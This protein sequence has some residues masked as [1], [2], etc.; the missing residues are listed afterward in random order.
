MRNE[1]WQYVTMSRTMRTSGP[2][3]ET[4]YERNCCLFQRKVKGGSWS[5]GHVAVHAR[6]LSEYFPA[7]WQDI[8]ILV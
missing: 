2:N 7:G 1:R 4:N 3:F 5:L 8:Q 6:L